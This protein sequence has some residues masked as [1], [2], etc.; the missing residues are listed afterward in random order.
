M[1]KLASLYWDMSPVHEM[2]SRPLAQFDL[3]LAWASWKLLWAIE[4][5]MECTNIQFCERLGHGWQFHPLFRAPSLFCTYQSIYNTINK[6]TLIIL[7]CFKD[8]KRY[9]HILN[10]IFDLAWPK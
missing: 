1:K 6:L 5:I 3:I 2:A 9:I 7:N 4:I 10:L 8:Y